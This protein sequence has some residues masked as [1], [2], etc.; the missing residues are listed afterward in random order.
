MIEV[1]GVWVQ[2]DLLGQW[3][4][5]WLDFGIVDGFIVLIY[6]DLMLVKVVFYGV[7][8]WQVV[9]VL[10][11]VL[12]C[13]WLYGLC[14]N[15]EFLVNVLCYLVFFDGVIDIG[16]FDMYGMVELLILL[17]DIVI[18]WLLVI[19]V[20]LVDVEYN[21]VSVGVFS[22]I[23]SGWCNLVLGYQV[24]IYCDDVD[25]EY[26]VEYWFIRMG[27]VFFGDLVVQLVLV[28][29]DQVVFVQDGVVYGFM[30][31]CYGF[32]VYVDLVCGF[33]YLV[34]LLCFFELSLVV[35]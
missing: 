19:V 13:V 11:D 25:I 23:F 3:I 14:I 4:G 21:W 16:F 15:C 8:C 30:V 27:L 9:F 2:F 32:D 17:V 28:D 5:I 31:V 29:V 35:E 12:V 7:I 10:V 33:V 22:L 6:Y 1:L 18:F 34:V 24:K 26:C 20:V